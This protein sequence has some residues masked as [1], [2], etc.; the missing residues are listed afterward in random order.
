MVRY[1]PIK[2]ATLV[3]R[4]SSHGPK[5][6]STVRWVHKV[7]LYCKGLKGPFLL[8]TILEVHFK[9]NCPLNMSPNGPKRMR[10]ESLIHQCDESP[11]N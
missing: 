7:Q 10:D 4:D 2:G 6:K 8:I 11:E 5:K 9:F 1:G 3:C